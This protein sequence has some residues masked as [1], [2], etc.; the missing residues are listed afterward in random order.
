[1]AF[2]YFIIK[3]SCRAEPLEVINVNPVRPE[4][5]VQVADTLDSTESGSLANPKRPVYKSIRPTDE[6]IYITDDS[7]TQTKLAEKVTARP[8]LFAGP[9]NSLALAQAAITALVP[10]TTWMEHT[11]SE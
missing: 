10:S 1:M 4:I 5:I 11:E 6:G 2:Q 8:D 9:Y 3:D 7:A